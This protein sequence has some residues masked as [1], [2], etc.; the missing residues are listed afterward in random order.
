MALKDRSRWVVSSGMATGM[1]MPGPNPWQSTLVRLKL[2]N[3]PKLSTSQWHPGWQLLTALEAEASSNRSGHGE[4][5]IGFWKKEFGLV[6][7]RFV[8]SV[9]L[10]RCFKMLLSVSQNHS[11]DV[12]VCNINQKIHPTSGKASAATHTHTYRSVQF[13]YI[14]TVWCSNRSKDLSQCLS[15]YIVLFFKISLFFRHSVWISKT[16]IFLFVFLC[17]LCFGTVEIRQHPQRF[18]QNDPNLQMLSSQ[19]RAKCTDPQLQLFFFGHLKNLKCLHA[20]ASFE[21]INNLKY[22]GIKL[23]Y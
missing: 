9:T 5:A 22:V 11:D 8:F 10:M 7:L 20:H 18:L 6:I 2:S 4:G 19:H 16:V 12:S 21:F 17:F 3:R 14:S 1:E 23:F 15:Y 13:R